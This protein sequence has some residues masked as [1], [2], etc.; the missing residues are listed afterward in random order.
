MDYLRSIGQSG[1]LLNVRNISFIPIVVLSTMQEAD[2]GPAVET[3]ADVCFD[4]N[5]PPPVISILL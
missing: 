5:L 4:S 3:G 2:V 1:W